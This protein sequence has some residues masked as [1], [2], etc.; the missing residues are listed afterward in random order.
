MAKSKR[1]RLT[2]PLSRFVFPHLNSPDT[3]FDPVGTYHVDG[4]PLDANAGERLRRAVDEWVQAAVDGV[5][6]DPDNGIVGLDPRQKK[7][8]DKAVAADKEI[9]ANDPPYKA[10]DEEY[11]GGFLF[12]F[13]MNPRGR[14][15][16]GEEYERSPKIFDST[17]K[18]IDVFVRTGTEGFISFE[19]Y[20]YYSPGFG[21][22]GV[23]L[24]LAAVQITELAEGGGSA[25]SFGFSEVEG[26]SLEDAESDFD[27]G[28]EG[29]E[30]ATGYDFG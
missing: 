3:K 10:Q 19:P 6:A 27:S 13:K 21:G 1:I 30:A 4:N 2:T 12:T 11:G 8:W 14:T 15:R 7:A 18:A 9:T 20:C 22:A 16:N 25:E 23:S 26:Y 28:E 24:R 29:E 5:A 17:G